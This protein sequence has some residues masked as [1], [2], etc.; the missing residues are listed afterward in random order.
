MPCITADGLVYLTSA[1]VNLTTDYVNIKYSNNGA[2]STK[3]LAILSETDKSKMIYTYD[4]TALVMN[5]T[6]TVYRYDLFN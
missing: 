1:V 4:N 5:S 6:N 2:T 3:Y